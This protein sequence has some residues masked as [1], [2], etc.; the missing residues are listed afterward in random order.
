MENVYPYVN[1]LIEVG[2]VSLDY[3]LFRG[4][5]EPVRDDM[6]AYDNLFNASVDAF[7]W[8]M[9]KEGFGGWEVVVAES[10][11][12]EGMAN[13]LAFN[14]NVVRRAVRGAGTPKRPSVGV[15]VYLFGLFDENKKVGKEY[16]RHF[17]LNG[18]RAYNLN[19]S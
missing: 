11:E 17:G 2:H 4:G 19:F 12:A 9:E 10:G 6:L 5:G 15:E 7:A 16:E 14:G 3:E 13:V 8:V 18:T 1:Y